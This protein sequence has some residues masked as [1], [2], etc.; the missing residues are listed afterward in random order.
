MF[1]F[2]SFIFCLLLFPFSSFAYRNVEM[3]AVWIATVANIDWPSDKTSSEAQR[4]QLITI[5][6]SLQ[7]CNINTVVFQVR[8]TS[9]TF[10]SSELEPWS[11]YLTGHQGSAPSPYYDPLQFL[12][13]EAHKRCME[14]HIWMN[15]YRVLNGDN[16]GLLVSNHLYYQRPELFKHYGGK[17]YFNPALQ[18]VRDYLTMIVMDIVLR[19]DVDAVHFDD[20]FY[21]YKVEGKEFP[22]DDSF[23]ADPRGFSSK[24]D[25]R[26]DNVNQ[27]ISQLQHTIKAAKPWVQFGVS[28]FGRFEDDYNELYADVRTWMLN[29]WIDYVVPQLYWAIGHKTSDFGKLYDWWA[30]VSESGDNRKTFNCNFYSGLY[31]AGTDIYA[32]SPWQT[33]NEV[34]RQVRLSQKKNRDKGSFF[35]SCHYFLSNKQGLLDS[36]RSVYYRYPALTPAVSTYGGLASD[37]PTGL[38][39]S[40]NKLSWNPVFCEGG[41]E[42]SYYVVYAVPSNKS[43][44]HDA[45]YI[46][47]KSQKS[48]LNLS[49]YKKKLKPGTQLMVT[50]FNR[51]REESDPSVSILWK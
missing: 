17:I 36:L 42:I 38:Q 7:S 43:F 47:A 8:P 49:K 6:D 29:G 46:L 2:I 18:D 45:A 4:K 28:P 1:R 3:R 41:N 48:E 9:D 12:I 22:D 19:Y 24:A 13:D 5:L 33:P 32:Y 27:I 34:V 23:A 35:Y 30:D 15:P 21:P 44:N 40:D 26:R 14:V 10:Y 16:T 39:I 50:S 31:V 25:W 20:Y 11:Q 37:A 51:F